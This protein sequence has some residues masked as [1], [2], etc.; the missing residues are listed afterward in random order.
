[1]ALHFTNDKRRLWAID[2]PSGRIP[3][4]DAEKYEHQLRW[5]DYPWTPVEKPVSL[6]W[7]GAG[8]RRA[9]TLWY[10]PT[11]TGGIIR[12]AA[13]IRAV[14]P[15][16]VRSA[17]SEIESTSGHE[18]AHV[19]LAVVSRCKNVKATINPSRD[20]TGK[21]YHGHC[22][23]E[24]AEN[25]SLVN[26]LAISAAGGVFEMMEYG[27]YIGGPDTAAVERK[28]TA[29][30]VTDPAKRKALIAEAHAHARAVLTANR[31]MV[32][33]L[34]KRLAAEGSYEHKAQVQTRR[35]ELPMATRSLELRSA[36]FDAK[37]MTV[38]VCWS[39]GAP[40]K[41][42]SYDGPFWEVLEMGPQNVRL[43]FFNSGK[44]PFLNSHRSGDTTDVL[45]NIVAGSV[46]LADGRG[47]ATVRLTSRA[48]AAETVADIRSGILASVS[49]G[50]RYH[51]VHEEKPGADGLPIMR[52]VDFE[53]LECSICA[54]PADQQAEIR[55]FEAVVVE[56]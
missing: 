20:S 18:A 38:E 47:F 2:N 13:P 22:S 16:P 27:R 10:E 52:V 40:V 56:R 41:R 31:E 4:T 24:R 37:A 34:A 53:P 25:L 15:E 32:R 6:N 28:L 35:V 45:G 48:S 14:A 44:A 30:G 23:F 43:D 39:S 33:E 5:R 36:S 50:Y 12:P 9:G 1:M 7:D 49:I 11:A 46:R 17:P 55:K 51:R 21:L 19:C 54:I 29:A 8:G 3:K 26:D 42:Q